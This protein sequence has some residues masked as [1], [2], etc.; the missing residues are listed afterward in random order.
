[1]LIVL[2]VACAV[3][4]SVWLAA[5][6]VQYRDVRYVTPFFLQTL[7]FVTPI[8]YVV[9]KVPPRN[10][11]RFIHSIRSSESYPA[12]VPPCSTSTQSPSVRWR[13]RVW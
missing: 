11:D 2:L 10:S 7:L 12:F 4:V 9:D 1:M 13:S 8:I 3:G 6:G 5:L